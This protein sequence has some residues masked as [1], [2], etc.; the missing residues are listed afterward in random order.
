VDSQLSY[1]FTLNIYAHDLRAAKTVKR[2]LERVTKTY[3]EEMSNYVVAASFRS[4]AE[5]LFELAHQ[6]LGGNYI[7]LHVV[8]FDS[9][10]TQE[11]ARI[12]A[13]WK[14]REEGGLSPHQNPSRRPASRRAGP[15]RDAYGRFV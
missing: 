6:Q 1:P 12:H 2:E 14:E 9:E 4:Q 3:Y 8:S 15:R 11:A 13:L 10:T 5:A 7:L